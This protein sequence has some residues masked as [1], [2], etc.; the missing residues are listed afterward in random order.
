MLDLGAVNDLVG[1][2][3]IMGVKDDWLDRDKLVY[4][5]E[6]KAFLNLDTYVTMV[7]G[8]IIEIPEG[9]WG[10]IQVTHCLV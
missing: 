4:Y 1:R 10:V 8:D 3:M 2:A 9:F 6:G 5:A 7:E